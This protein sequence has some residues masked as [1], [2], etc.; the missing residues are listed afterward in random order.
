VITFISQL[1]ELEVK[2]IMITMVFGKS[3]NTESRPKDKIR[4]RNVGLYCEFSITESLILK[5]CSRQS[6]TWYGENCDK[7]TSVCNY[8]I[9]RALQEGLTAEISRSA[10][11]LSN[12]TVTISK[13]RAE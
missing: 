5:R 2:I 1:Q 12:I 13:F 3:E 11:D 7:I 8:F 10:Y 9:Q 4:Y 6:L